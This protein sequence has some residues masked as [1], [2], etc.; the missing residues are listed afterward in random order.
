MAPQN[1]I[2]LAA[3]REFAEKED[4]FPKE[5]VRFLCHYGETVSVLI[6]KSLGIYVG[7][8][9]ALFGQFM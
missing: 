4:F 3:G 1:R 9:T 7:I 2:C 8:L 5:T 6:H